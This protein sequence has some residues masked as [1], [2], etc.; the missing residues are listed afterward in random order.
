MRRMPS[1]FMRE[2]SVCGLI[3]NSFAAPFSPLTRPPVKANAFSMCAR[4]FSSSVA[5]CPVSELMT[6]AY[7]S[8]RELSIS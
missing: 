7:C 6:L 2:V 1:F 3:A 5:I 4:S 8:I